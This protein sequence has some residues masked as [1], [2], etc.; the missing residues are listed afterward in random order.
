MRAQPFDEVIAI[1]NSKDKI[2]GIKVEIGSLLWGEAY[3]ADAN[4]DRTIDRH[5]RYTAWVC[6]QCSTGPTALIP[7]CPCTTVPKRGEDKGKV[8][9]HD[10]LAKHCMNPNFFPKGQ[11]EKPTRCKRA[12]PAPATPTDE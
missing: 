6:R 10:C 4:E 9:R 12:R 2:R 5:N 7:L 3:A 1:L 11:R 8:I